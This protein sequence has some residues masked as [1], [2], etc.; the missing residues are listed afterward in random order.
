[1]ENENIKNLQEALGF[2]PDNIPLR[3]HL[4]ELLLQESL[5][6]EAAEQFRETLNRNY[7][8]TRA[9]LGLAARITVSHHR[10]S[11]H[12]LYIDQGFLKVE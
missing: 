9:Q 6:T 3:L 2:S 11:Y 10:F 7:G 12:M 1:M 4:A 5:I 8:N